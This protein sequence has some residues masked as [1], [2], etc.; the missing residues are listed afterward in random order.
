MSQLSRSCK[1][2]RPSLRSVD[3]EA[4]RVLDSDMKPRSRNTSSMNSDMNTSQDR[5]SSILSVIGPGLLITL[6]LMDSLSSPDV[7]RLRLSKSNTITAR[8]ATFSLWINTCHWLERYLGR[9]S[10]HSLSSLLSS[11]TT[12][13]QVIQPA[14]DFVRILTSVLHLRLGFIYADLTG[15]GN[16]RGC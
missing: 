13:I 7:G 1:E 12:E 14:S 3:E 15:E 9:M 10:G 5:G 6:S 8:K 4:G 2:S 11:G 16:G